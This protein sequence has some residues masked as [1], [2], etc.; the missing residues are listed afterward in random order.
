M[1]LA[2]RVRGVLK[3]PAPAGPAAPVR[4][5]GGAIEEATGGEWRFHAGARHFVVERRIDAAERHGRTSVGDLAAALEANAVQASLLTG[6]VAARAPFVFLDLETTGLS[7]GAG[8]LAFLVGC[9]SFASDGSFVVRQHLMVSPADERAMLRAVAAEIEPA[10]ALVSFNGKSFD[11]P[12]LETRY[13]FHRLLWPAGSLTHVDALH[14]SRNFWGEV[15]GCSLSVLESQVL[16]TR[17]RADVSGMEIPARYFEFLRTGDAR[18]L[19]AVLEHNRLDLLSLAG[20]T[21]RLVELVAAGPSRCRSAQEAFALGRIYRRSGLDARAHGAFVRAFDLAPNG[22]SQV[23]TAA[24]HA[25]ALSDRHAR[26]YADAAD[27]WQ[28]LVE[29]PDCPA[30]VR[31]AAAEA[32]AIHHEHRVRNLPA[33]R[34]F[35]LK[36]LESPSGQAWRAAVRRRLTRIDRKLGEDIGRRAGID[37]PIQLLLYAA[38]GD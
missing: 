4:G 18:P 36:S 10:G 34:A 2:D 29:A 9:G 19:A 1:N 32:L 38:A 16:G 37:P 33:A 28:A 13:L 6:G 21:S 3:P 22:W 7:G 25:L 12:V 31:R 15:G 5:E 24:L 8:T 14:P 17:R 23:R 30:L 26:R 20:L 11:A 35:A 27:R